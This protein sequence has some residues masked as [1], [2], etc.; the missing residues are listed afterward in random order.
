MKNLLIISVCLSFY[1]NFSEASLPRVIYGEDNRKDYY[2]VESAT[3]QQLSKSTA[4]LFLSDMVGVMT[5]GDYY[6]QTAKYGETWG[7]CKDERFYHQPSASFCSGFLIAPDILATAGHCIS[8]QEACKNTTIVFNYAYQNAN[9]N[10]NYAAKEDVFKCHSIISRKFKKRGIDYALLK[11]DRTVIKVPP[12]KLNN[13]GRIDSTAEFLVMGHPGGLPL[14]ITDKAYLR[15]INYRQS[16]FVINSDTFIGNSGS[17]VINANSG[18]VEGILV[19]GRADYRKRRGGNCLETV[20]CSEHGCRGEEV[21]SS[22][23]FQNGLSLLR[24]QH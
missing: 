1:A 12:L 5:N 22:A 17:A 16:T 11:L 20:R 9:T 4:A 8:N 6:I 18:L 13:S 10:I 3:Y 19:R 14:K 21:T 24:S 7:L 15:K 23:A 2:E